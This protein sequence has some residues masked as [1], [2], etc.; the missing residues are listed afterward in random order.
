MPRYTLPPRGVEI[1][2]KML[3][4]QLSPAVIKTWGQLRGLAWGKDTTPQLTMD[5][6]VS[7]TGSKP[8]TLYEHMRLLRASYALSWQMAKKETFIFSFPSNDQINSSFLEWPSSLSTSNSLQEDKEGGA[9]YIPENQNKPGRQRATKATV[10]ADAL[11]PIVH[12]LANVTALDERMNYSSL[13]KVAK[14]LYQSEY[15]A[16]QVAK[17][18]GHGGKWW[19]DDWRGRKKE[20]PDVWVIPK[21]IKLLLNGSDPTPARPKMSRADVEQMLAELEGKA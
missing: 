6:L 19:T 17:V 21:T 7:L 11:K 4:S 14:L 9:D 8:S 10:P 1:P 15:T 18:Y 16:E 12:A 20:R 3:Y 5:E 2:S 13:S